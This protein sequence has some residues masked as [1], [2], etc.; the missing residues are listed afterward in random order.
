MI[1]S[2]NISKFFFYIVGGICWFVL[3]GI[4]QSTCILNMSLHI[5]ALWVKPVGDNLV[6]NLI[7]ATAFRVEGYGCEDKL[8]FVA[9]YYANGMNDKPQIKSLAK[10]IDLKT[11]KKLESDTVST[12]YI[13]NLHSYVLFQNSDGVNM[14]IYKK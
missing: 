13:D 3:L 6:K 8:I 10:L 11:W 4:L 7:G 12:T 14:K 2:W 1:K 9:P 5:D